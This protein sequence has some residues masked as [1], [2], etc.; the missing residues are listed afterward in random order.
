[1]VPL[2]LLYDNG[3][4]PTHG[5]VS[6]GT[7]VGRAVAAAGDAPMVACYPKRRWRG[8]VAICFFYII[9]YLHILIYTHISFP[10]YS[11]TT[12]M[13][14]LTNAMLLYSSVCLAH[15]MLLQ[16]WCPRISAATS[17]EFN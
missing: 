7:V 16:N 8:H 3:V 12:H 13:I 15:Q 9:S 4:I 10:S 5:A 11:C 6:A 14:L 2:S 1:M 17:G